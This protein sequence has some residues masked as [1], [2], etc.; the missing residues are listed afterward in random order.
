MRTIIERELERRKNEEIE[1]TDIIGYMIS[2]VVIFFALLIVYGLVT[3]QSITFD[4]KKNHTSVN[5]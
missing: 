3:D 5:N 4:L 1:V 2:G